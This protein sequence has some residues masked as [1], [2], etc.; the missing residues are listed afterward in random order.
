MGNTCLKNKSIFLIICLD[1]GGT[2]AIMSV[3]LGKM[4]RSYRFVFFKLPQQKGL[5]VPL[6]LLAPDYKQVLTL[7]VVVDYGLS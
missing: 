6:Q 3:N 5:G 1:D 7:Q 2:C 4:G